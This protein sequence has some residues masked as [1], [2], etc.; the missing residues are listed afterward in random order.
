MPETA[1]ELT[2]VALMGASM[3]RLVIDIGR[4]DIEETVVVEGYETVSDVLGTPNCG[5]NV[6]YGELGGSITLWCPIFWDVPISSCC[7]V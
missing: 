3:R 5:V 6:F 7:I 4:F 2:N 1:R